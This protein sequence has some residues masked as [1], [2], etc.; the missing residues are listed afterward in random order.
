MMSPGLYVHTPFCSRRCPY[1]DFYSISDLAKIPRWL[2]ALE[3]EVSHQSPYWTDLFGTVYVGGGSPSL[4]SPDQL[5]GLKNALSKLKISPKAEI[6]LEANPED[7]TA[8]KAQAWAR[9]GF[10]RISLGAQSFQNQALSGP[11]GRGHSAEDIHQ[12]IEIIRRSKLTLS[13]DLIFGWPGQSFQDWVDDLG[14]AVEAGVDHLS[15]YCLTPGPK[16]PLA[17]SYLDRTLTPIP[18]GQLADM[19]L[20]AGVFLKKRGFERYEVA[21]F[22]RR[23]A[24]S[25]HNLKYWRRDSYLGL[26]PSAHSF[27][28][29]RRSANVDC[30]E[31]WADSL[32]NGHT[33]LS[34][35]EDIT[36]E[37][38]MMESLM[39]SLRLAEGAPLKWVKDQDQAQRLI[40]DGYLTQRGGTLKPTEKGFLNADYLARVLT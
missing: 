29:T 20:E 24:Y 9:W 16:S 33:A 11:L 14:L 31:R 3:R 10:N 19:F 35:I 36:P 39:L 25:Q 6:T 1:C 34:V 7:V 22:A 23:G 21:N 32:G 4:L 27:D 38:A 30:L 28:G 15:A 12:A 37:Q 2:E 8:E 13:L 5:A 18:E 17:K 40:Q 26:G